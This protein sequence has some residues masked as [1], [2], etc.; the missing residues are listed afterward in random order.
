MKTKTD[1]RKA[2]K[3]LINAFAER[4]PKP[5]TLLDVWGTDVERVILDTDWANA[6]REQI[7]IK[8]TEFTPNGEYWFNGIHGTW[9]KS[10]DTRVA[11]VFPVDYK[12]QVGSSR[13]FDTPKGRIYDGDALGSSCPEEAANKLKQADIDMAN[14]IRDVAYHQ[15]TAKMAEQSSQPPPKPSLSVRLDNWL[16]R[17]I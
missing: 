9:C 3:R 17:L 6:G 14:A 7:F 10:A 12:K 1:K 15:M 5:T 4:D 16:K 2:A 13:L 8:K 11:Y